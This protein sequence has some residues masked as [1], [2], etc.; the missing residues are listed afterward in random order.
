M[1]LALRFIATLLLYSSVTYA[2]NA[3][4]GELDAF[5]AKTGAA[6]TI[7]RATSSVSSLRFPESRPLKL[8]GGTLQEKALNF[9]SQNSGIFAVQSGKDGYKVKES[10]KDNYGMEHVA[11][12]QYVSGV[13]VFDGVLKFH[14]NKANDLSSLNGNF[15]KVEKLNTR[16]TISKE[17]ADALAIK[18]VLSQKTREFKD[19]PKSPLKVNKSTLYVFQKG[20]AQGYEGRKHLVYEVEVRNDADVREF[21]Y[22]DAHSKELVEQFAGMHEVLNREL[23]TYPPGSTTSTVPTVTWV[24][25]QAFPGA[26]DTWQQSEIV[27][28]GQIYHMMKNAFGHVSYDDNDAKMITTHNNPGISCPNANWNGVTANYC[29]GIATDDVVAHEW[30]HAYTEYTS[31]L[32]YA[33]QAGALNEAY[34]DIWGETVDQLNNY[35]DGGEGIAMRPPSGGDC[36][37]VA[38]TSRWRV[39]EQATSPNGAIRDMYN[40]NCFNDPGRVLDPIYYCTTGQPTNSNDQ[41]GVHIN[42]GVINHAYALLVDG[43]TYNGQTITGIGLTKA[44]H[45]FWYAQANFMGKT[46]DFAAQADILEA[47][48]QAL[49][50]ANVNLPNLSTADALPTLSGQFISAADL[51][52]LRKVLLAVEMRA[53]NTCGYAPLL[54]PVATLCAGANTPLFSYNF[55]SGLGVGPDAWTVLS[56]PVD[57]AT[58]FTRTWVLNSAAPDNHPGNAISAINYP[59][60]DCAGDNE[61]GVMSVLSP[62]MAIPAG[63]PTD[64]TLAFDHY[65]SLESGYDGGNVRYKIGAGAWILVPASAF[66]ANGYN[67]TLVTTAGG[68]T[69][70]LAGQGAFSGADAGS[71]SGT[72]G[73]SRINLT[74]LGVDPGESVQFRWDLGTDGCGG[75]D[76][77]YL[78]DVR[79]YSCAVPGVQFVTT[80]TIVNE[81]EA[82]NPGPGSA[83]CLPYLEKIVQ[84]KINQAPTAPVTVTFNTPTGT[85]TLGATA[86]YSFSPASVIL[87]AGSLMQDVTVRIYNDVYVEGQETAVLSYTLSGGNGIP[88]SI[89]QIHTITIQDNEFLPGVNTVEVLNANFNDKALPPGWSGGNIYPDDWAVVWGENPNSVFLDTNMPEGQ[90]FL[91]ADSDSYGDGERTWSIETAPFNTSGMTSLNLSF[92]EAFRVYNAAGD[93]AESAKVDVWDGAAWHNLLTHTEASGTSGAYGAANAQNIAIPIV[94]ANAAMKLR[95]QYTANWDYYWALDNIKVTGQFPTQISTTVTAPPDEQYLGPLATAYFYDPISK[96]LIAKIENLTTHDYGCTSVQIDRAGTGSEEWVAAYR[97]TKKTVKVTPSNP[98]PAG[99]YNITLYYTDTELGAYQES[100]T[101]MGKS[102][103]GITIDNTGAGS[104]AEIQ[105]SSA[106]NTDWAYTA[107]FTSGFSGFGLSNA[108]PVGSLPVTLVKFEGKHSSEGNLLKWAT[109]AEVNSDFFAVERASDVKKFSEIGR[110]AG[111][112]N[113]AITNNYTFTDSKYGRGLNYYRLRSVDKDGS[114]AYSKIIAI[115]A[116]NS[117]ETKSFPNPVQSVLSIELPDVDMKLV[118]LKVINVSGQ[119][120]IEQSKVKANGGVVTQDMSKL[121]TGVYQVVISDDKASYNFSVLKL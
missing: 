43:G 64:L 8:T 61:S 1:K 46:T 17:V 80:T 47:A 73:Q 78:D 30:G 12:Q 98:N 84:V 79:I 104:F 59:G 2:Q 101:S 25:G 10:K 40:P 18:M 74:A 91:I 119:V 33:W 31:G 4:Q 65:I 116:H 15:I 53:E 45:I 106:F 72:W 107:K 77:W 95:F 93:F 70:P 117:R 26:L 51:G 86:D 92:L 49:I 36:P 28:A 110:V 120:V 21:L 68:N 24:E 38:T 5:V 111:N 3:V 48:A 6:P 88:E 105:V 29:V 115:D 62:V 14:F 19:P 9:I 50:T 67:Q 82:V 16:P 102:E 44:A 20:L 99:E 27:S 23:R 76:G 89:N 94:Y 112:G 81:A 39:G 37:T 22:I 100:I 42:S 56:T 108:P 118:T 85:A 66:V 87:Q 97:I 41:G 103:D 121:G 90:P 52:Q 54:K 71:V 63:A 13:P 96:N 57:N 58:W 83:D 11:L 55:E 32:I 109:T 7:D 60:G 69:D 35:F 113:S 34:S 114:L 75:W